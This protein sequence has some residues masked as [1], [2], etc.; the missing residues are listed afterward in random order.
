M[1]SPHQ[2]DKFGQMQSQLAYHH[3]IWSLEELAS[4]VNAIHE[5]PPD[6]KA[7]ESSFQGDV[8]TK[9]AHWNRGSEAE[10]IALK[11]EVTLG[12][13]SLQRPGSGAKLATVY[14]HIPL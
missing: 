1:A 5:H 12:G 6:F 9:P 14:T 10:A 3:P 13:A 8:T 11:Q 2:V 7:S 4:K